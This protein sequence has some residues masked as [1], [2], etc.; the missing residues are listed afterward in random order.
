[1]IKGNV[2][3]RIENLL[4][5]K[6][7]E[8]AVKLVEDKG[9]DA[10]EVACLREMG[11]VVNEYKKER[12]TMK[13][14][15][16][17][18]NILCVGIFIYACLTLA[19]LGLLITTSFILAA[20]A[21]INVASDKVPD[22]TLA[23]ISASFKMTI[24]QF[25]KLGLHEKIALLNSVIDRS[26]V[27]DQLNNLNNPIVKT[28]FGYVAPDA[29]KKCQLEAEKSSLTNRI[30]SS[31]ALVQK[32]ILKNNYEKEKKL[33]LDNLKK[34]RDIQASRIDRKE[35]NLKL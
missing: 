26:N 35:K 15:A 24:K 17:G 5:N 20:A 8:D 14:M 32:M 4:K 19:P 22:Q 34:Q 1:M 3:S 11:R 27:N 21:G 2:L 28:D 33:L 30:E 23:D 31:I 7:V 9:I 18:S 6:Y 16:F 13:R 29:S 25:K 12:R 10:E